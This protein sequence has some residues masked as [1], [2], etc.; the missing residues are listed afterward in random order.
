MLYY[1][2]IF[3]KPNIRDE[4]TPNYNIGIFKVKLLMVCCNNTT[5]ENCYVVL[6]TP[7]SAWLPLF[8][9]SIDT[10]MDTVSFLP[11]VFP[12]KNSI[13]C[14]NHF[15]ELHTVISLVLHTL[16]YLS[17]TWKKWHKEAAASTSDNNNN[18]DDIHTNNYDVEDCE[19]SKAVLYHYFVVWLSIGKIF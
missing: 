9:S 16:L 17:R 5:R 14:Y 19:C 8:I 2:Y 10:K 1:T 18:N 13:L 7:T 3:L 4:R 12:S 15:N 11:S 6:P